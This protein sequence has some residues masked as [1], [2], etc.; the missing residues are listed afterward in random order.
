MK[1]SI[2]AIC[3]CIFYF[4][5]SSASPSP[6]RNDDP[7]RP[8]KY[9]NSKLCKDRLKENGCNSA[10]TE[11]AFAS[12]GG[13]TESAIV[14]SRPPSGGADVVNCEWST[15]S[16]S[17][18]CSESCGGGYQ[19]YV[20]SHRI[21]SKN[22]GQDCDGLFHKTEPCN[23]H[24]CPFGHPNFLPSI[25]SIPSITGIPSIPSIDNFS[26]LNCNERG[27]CAN[28]ITFDEDE[29]NCGGDYSC[30]QI[31]ASP[32]GNL[33]INCRGHASCKNLHVH[34]DFRHHLNIYCDGVSS[35]EGLTVICPNGGN[36]CGGR[37][38][39]S[40]WCGVNNKSVCKRIQSFAQK[41]CMVASDITRKGL[42]IF[43]ESSTGVRNKHWRQTGRKSG[44]AEGE[45]E[46]YLVKNK[47]F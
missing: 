11:S 30:R 29:I 47:L 22:G 42:G 31:S 15:W 38:T 12:T 34:G 25:L 43:S 18:N 40:L 44:D 19:T 1:V 20:R 8:C 9:P 39:C 32:F 6:Q 13:T 23:T 3:L 5:A 10:T 45:F 14:T 17:G 33:T 28:A 26:D 46:T 2:I 41:N 36:W 21:K 16:S 4:T 24:S 27:S 35:C 7:C 37:S